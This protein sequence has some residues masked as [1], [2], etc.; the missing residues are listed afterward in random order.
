[1][2][3]NSKALASEQTKFEDNYGTS[4]NQTGVSCYLKK[5][6]VQYLINHSDGDRPPF[7]YY[8]RAIGNDRH[9][10][11]LGFG[12]FLVY[13]ILLL[14]VLPPFSSIVIKLY[15]TFGCIVS[16][17][18]GLLATYW[19][20][21]WRKQTFLPGVPLPVVVFSTYIL[22]LDIFMTHPSDCVEFSSI[23]QSQ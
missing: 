23:I 21:Q 7:L 4:S 22:L 18:T 9:G 16:I 3:S 19:L 15:V 20:G 2:C 14:L 12:D 13:N 10:T 1:M 6:I 5:I 17:I 11:A 8:T